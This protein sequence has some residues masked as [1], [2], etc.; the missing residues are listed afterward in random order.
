ML[1]SRHRLDRTSILQCASEEVSPSRNFCTGNTLGRRPGNALGV[2]GA[3]GGRTGDGRSVRDLLLGRLQLPLQACQLPSKVGDALADWDLELALGEDIDTDGL[4]DTRLGRALD[5][6]LKA[7]VSRINA[8]VLL[9][10][11]RAF[12]LDTCLSHT[13]TTGLAVYGDYTFCTPG[14]PEDPDAA[15]N[16]TR[17]YSKDFRP[18]LKQVVFS[19]TVANDGFVPLFG[20]VT[21]GNRSDNIEGVG[22]LASALP[23]PG[24]MTIVGDCRLLTGPNIAL[25]KKSGLNFVTSLPRSLNAWKEA[26]DKA[27]DLLDDGPVL[28]ESVEIEERYED[29]RVEVVAEEVRETWRG[30]SLKTTH[31]W[32]EVLED[33]TTAK[34][35]EGLRAVV[36]RSEQLARAKRR[37]LEALIAKENQALKKLAGGFRSEKKGFAC[38]TQRR[39]R[40]RCARR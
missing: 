15:P 1:P 22:R 4:S 9:E 12:D 39:W 33:G 40:R 32:K 8:G 17:G 36:I 7:G 19:L 10:A 29:D 28:R 34:H 30:I 2:G 14:D 24:Q 27:R 37:S 18:D 26:Y 11:V 31:K 3:L 35:E 16:V 38:R 21:D 6:V 23:D 5:C 20:H 13:D 25:A